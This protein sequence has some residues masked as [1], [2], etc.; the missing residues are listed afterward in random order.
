[1]TTDIKN[2]FIAFANNLN[3]SG[4]SINSFIYQTYV[5]VDI[6]K[7]GTA[8]KKKLDA[9]VANLRQNHTETFEIVERSP[10]EVSIHVLDGSEV[11]N[12]DFHKAAIYFAMQR[13]IEIKERE[14][15]CSEALLKV[16]KRA[17]NDDF[18]AKDSLNK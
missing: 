16:L 18:K 6:S 3:G 12:Y 8:G 11:A 15:E 2:K 10:G 4:Q 5:I 9:F 13:M 1:M 17:H 7:Y 14:L